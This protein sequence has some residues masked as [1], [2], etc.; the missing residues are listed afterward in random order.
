[1][2]VRE[3]VY[4]CTS[5]QRLPA[6]HCARNSGKVSLTYAFMCVCVC[7]STIAATD[8]TPS[9]RHLHNMIYK[10]HTITIKGTCA[11]SRWTLLNVAAVYYCYYYYN[12]Y[13][14]LDKHVCPAKTSFTK[15]IDMP[16]YYNIPPHHTLSRCKHW[17]LLHYV[18]FA[19]RLKF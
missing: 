18:L 10:V 12:Y 19:T 17:I 3:S 16:L 5:A 9:M 15:L 7:V 6:D 13:H 2:C 4:V 8:F 14:I 11:P 1:M